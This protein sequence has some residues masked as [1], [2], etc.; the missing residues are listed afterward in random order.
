MVEDELGSL[1]I[2]GCHSEE[3]KN[4]RKVS[5]YI[6]SIPCSNAHTE[7]VFSMMTTA[8]RNERNLLEVEN[9]E[10][11][12]QICINFTDQCT[13]IYKKFLANKKL[14]VQRGQSSL[15]PS[16]SLLASTQPPT[17]LLPCLASNQRL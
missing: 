4:L 1:E 8:W 17:S 14:P 15:L 9:V 13:E 3:Q 12:L 11:K 7:R 10:A 2:E 6:F 5:A 16:D